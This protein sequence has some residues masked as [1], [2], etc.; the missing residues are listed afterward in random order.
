MGTIT[1]QI[2]V[3]NP[4]LYHG[5]IAP[6]HYLFLSENSRPAWILINQNIIDQSESKENRIVWIPSVENMLEDALAMIAI[7][8]IKNQQ[9]I[10]LAQKMYKNIEGP[11]LEVYENL[12]ESQRQELYKE[13]RRNENWPKIVVTVLNGSS[14]KKQVSVLKKYS[15]DAEV[16]ISK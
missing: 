2:L 3:G 9:I 10:D 16:C 14:I 6:S 13:C 12:T 1:A 5:G 4:H 15:I 11:H 7:H 8:V